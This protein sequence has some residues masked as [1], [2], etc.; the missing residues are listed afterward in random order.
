M[1][2]TS[3]TLKVTYSN[4]DFKLIV[5]LTKT[6]NIKLIPSK[7]TFTNMEHQQKLTVKVCTLSFELISRYLFKLT[8]GTPHICTGY[9][10][11]KEYLEMNQDPETVR[12]FT[13]RLRFTPYSVS[14]SFLS[15]KKVYLCIAQAYSL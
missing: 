4:V 10:Q 15:R 14:T 5:Y 6:S 9:C 3:Q 2:C 1:Y 11:M 13:V 12:T 8:Y 7:Q